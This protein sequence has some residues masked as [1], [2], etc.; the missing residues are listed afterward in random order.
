MY[1]STRQFLKAIVSIFIS[2]STIK[3]IKKGDRHRMKFPIASRLATYLCT[4]FSSCSCIEL[5]TCLVFS[6]ATHILN[7]KVPTAYQLDF[8]ELFGSISNNRDSTCFEIVI[9]LTSI[10]NLFLLRGTHLVQIFLV[11]YFSATVIGNEIYS[12]KKNDF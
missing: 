9:G 5:L 3:Y 8:W 11:Q 12:I 4:F 10:P 7:F 6:T 2:V 1:E